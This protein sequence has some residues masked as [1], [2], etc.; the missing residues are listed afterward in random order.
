MTDSVSS[1]V[2]TLAVWDEIP[3]GLLLADRSGVILAVNPQLTAM[4][5]ADSAKLVGQPVEILLPDAVQSGHQFLRMG[6]MQQPDS[7]KM[8]VLQQIHGQRFDRTIF[9]VDVSL[10]PIDDG[11]QVV[12]LA[13]IRDLSEA[14]ARDRKMVAGTRARLLAEDHERIARD[15]H[16]TVIQELFAVGMGLQ[17][18]MTS[19]ASNEVMVKNIDRAVDSLDAVIRTVRSV[20]FDVVRGD[21]SGT[22]LREALIDVAAEMSL[23][24][25]FEPV[26]SFSGPIDQG[27]PAAVADD[28]VA[29]AREAVA[30]VARHADSDSAWIDLAMVDGEVRLVVTDHGVGLPDRGRGVQNGPIAEPGIDGHGIGNMTARAANHEGSLSV[31]TPIT[32]GTVVRWTIPTYWLQK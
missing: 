29:V 20:I 22:L 9:P 7:R 6:Y 8:G 11:E 23:A 10:A 14:V 18:T 31:E 24:L 13:A 15:L 5:G 19:G 21:M 1:I 3:D 26:V 32:G 17:A 16:D 4:F 27:F 30:N 12:I 28:V 2:T 25:G